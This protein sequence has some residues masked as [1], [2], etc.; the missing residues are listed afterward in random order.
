[1]SSII[2]YGAA[3]NTILGRHECCSSDISSKA[4]RVT[5][6]PNLHWTT[7]AVDTVRYNMTISANI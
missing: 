5:R 2:Y 1:V 3:V 7:M 6:L 4:H